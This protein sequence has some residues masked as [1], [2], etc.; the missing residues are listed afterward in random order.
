MLSSYL[1]DTTLDLIRELQRDE[2]APDIKVL[3]F[4]EFVAT[5]E[6]LAE[7]LGS[8]SFTVVRLNGSM[9]LEERRAAQDTFATGSQ[10][11]V[12]TE[13]GGEGLNLQFCHVVVNYDLPWN[14]MRVEQRIGRVDRIGQKEIVRA[15]NFALADTVEL[16]VR[17][18]LEEKLEVI[19]REFGVD[20]LGD[21]L[22]SEMAGVD[23]DELYMR[24]M[25]DPEQAEANVETFIEELRRQARAS[26]EGLHVLGD[27]PELDPTEAKRLEEHQLPFWTE[28]M[29]VAWLRSQKHRGATV[30]EKPSPMSR[31]R[32][33][34]DLRFPDGSEV[35]GAVFSRQEASISGAQLVSIEDPRVRALLDGLPTY[36]PG[37]PIASVAIPGVSDKVTG[38]WSLW[39]VAL[40]TSS[41]GKTAKKQ[42][43]LP[44]FLSADGAVLL[45]AA[46]VVWDRLISDSSLAI[47]AASSPDASDRP[48]HTG[49]DESII[50]ASRSAAEEHGAVLYQE[51]VAGHQQ[52]LS[53]E[54]SKWRHAFEARRRAIHRVGLPQVLDHRR[55]QLAEDKRIWE[56]RMASQERAV[57]ELVPILLLRVAR[58]AETS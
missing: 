23:F 51:L 3:V 14:P 24:A 1:L 10:V 41:D 34:Y 21:V 56:D 49:G 54:R 27:S 33:R 52:R 8:R 9:G 28:Q 19:L 45:P 46:R 48:D 43:I 12:S 29:T 15:F 40:E 20:K 2:G 32:W 57:P 53:R 4:T 58:Q 17:E 42:R 26:R 7:F 16:R 35:N 31:D 30:R 36:A 6:M 5:Q 47:A 18:V 22:D 25:L 44:L 38:T 11:M 37:Q 39:R 13:A 50:D 55:R